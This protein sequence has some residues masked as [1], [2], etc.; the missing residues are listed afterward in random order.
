MKG[1]PYPQP[2][3]HHAHHW[4]YVHHQH[5]ALRNHHHHQH[6]LIHH[7][8]PSSLTSKPPPV[9]AARVPALPIESLLTL[10]LGCSCHF[11]LSGTFWA[12]KFAE[13]YELENYSLPH[14][15]SC[16][17][18]S[19]RA[20]TA[21]ISTSATTSSTTTKLFYQAKVEVVIAVKQTSLLKLLGTQSKYVLAQNFGF[22]S[23]LILSRGPWK[24]FFELWSY[25]PGSSA[26]I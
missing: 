10:S 16:Q 22:R 15:L 11:L 19:H 12:A 17:A 8:Y 25:R 20:C 6:H 13:Q 1:L 14:D 7:P 2:E 5:Y 21:T 3:S 24:S 18:S 4:R 26:S 23:S 9:P